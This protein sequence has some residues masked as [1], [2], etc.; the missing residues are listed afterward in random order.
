MVLSTLDS[1]FSLIDADSGTIGIQYSARY[2]AAQPFPHIVIDDFLDEQAIEL[3]LREF[4]RREKAE[5]SYNRSQE[6]R[7][8]EYKPESLAPSVRTLFYSFNSLP[9]LRFLE[10]V[11]GIKGL[12]PDPYFLGG[13]FHEVQNGGYLNIHTDFNHHSL[14]GL[15]RRINVLIYLNKEW[16]EEYGGSLELWDQKMRACQ[17]RIIPEFNRCVIFNTSLTSNHGNPEPV[18]HPQGAP[19]RAIALYYYTATWDRSRL[20]RTTRFSIRPNRGDSFDFRVRANELIEDV[21][22]PLLLRAVRK[23][24]RLVQRQPET[25]VHPDDGVVVS[26]KSSGT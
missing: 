15:E 3:C 10:N 12:I 13:G 20:S 17:A 18:A 2:A 4:P 16:K 24:G 8:L 5:A 22:P 6:K 9:F 23:L 11:T 1:P 25:A 21:A 19:R 7:K 26:A 14:L